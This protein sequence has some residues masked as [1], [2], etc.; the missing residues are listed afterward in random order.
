MSSDLSASK[1]AEL[2]KSLTGK[3]CALLVIGY[4]LQEEKDGKEYREEIKTIA[5]SISPYGNDR[6]RQEYL[7]YYKLWYNLTLFELDFQTCMLD[8]QI[9]DKQLQSIALALVHDAMN[10]HNLL[11]FGWTP[12]IITEKQFEDLYEQER[13]ERLA[14]VIPVEAVAKYEAFVCLKNAGYFPKDSYPDKVNKND[15]KWKQT[16]SEELSKLKSAIKNGKLKQAKVSSDF[17]WYHNGKEYLGQE[18]ILAQSWYENPEKLDKDF[19]THLDNKGEL[20]EWE[21]GRYAVAKD[22][23]LLARLN[24]SNLPDGEDHRLHFEKRLKNILMFKEEGSVLDFADKSYKDLVLLRLKDTQEWIQRLL[25]HTEVAYKVEGI[26]GREV[27]INKLIAKAKG[28]ISQVVEKQNKSIPELLDSYNVYRKDTKD[29][30]TFK[31][32]GKY[33]LTADLKPEAEWVDD[34]I[35]KL[36]EIANE[37]SGYQYELDS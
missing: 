27:S 23:T 31:D 34:T 4:Y 6:K 10:Y 30:F 35:K 15:G 19:N 24:K 12:K 29:A 3:D 17:G 21:H 11:L 16:L 22:G 2:A 14:E 36:I 13:T 32:E 25:N 5:A 1:L 37:E 9:M 26:F 33:I 28:L 8:L 7:F 20:V 18:G